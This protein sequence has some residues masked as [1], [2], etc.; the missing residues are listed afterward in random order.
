MKTIKLN[1]NTQAILTNVSRERSEQ[2]INNATDVAN[3]ASQAS[4]ANVNVNA[5][6]SAAGITVTTKPVAPQARLTSLAK[7]TQSLALMAKPS[8]ANNAV[9]SDPHR[10]TRILN[11]LAYT[12]DQRSK[13]ELAE[14]ALAEQSA[15]ANAS[16]NASINANPLCEEPVSSSLEINNGSNGTSENEVS[17]NEVSYAGSASSA[18]SAIRYD[19]SQLAAINTI[20]SSGASSASSFGYVLIGAA[21]SGKTTVINEVVSRLEKAGEIQPLA[22]RRYNGDSISGFNICF[23]S[24]TGKAVEQMRKHIPPRYH[25]CCQ[26]IHSLLEYAPELIESE[27]PDPKSASG[28]KTVTHKVFLPRRTSLNKLP[29]NLFFIDESGMVGVELWNNLYQ[30]IDFTLPNI[31]IVLIG[32]VY[33][34]PAVIGKSVLGYALNSTRWKTNSLTTIHRQALDN[35]IVLNAHRVKQGLAPKVETLPPEL[36]SRFVSPTPFNMLDLRSKGAVSANAEFTRLCRVIQSLFANGHFDPSLDQIITP[37]N[38]GL[39]G[40]ENLNA[41]LAPVFNPASRTAI[42]ISF[43]SKFLAVGDKVMFTSNDYAKGILNGMNGVVTSISLNPKYEYFHEMLRQQEKEANDSESLA[44]NTNEVNS[45][46]DEINKFSLDLSSDRKLAEKELQASHVV[47]VRYTPLGSVVPTEISLSSVGDLRGLLLSYAITCH[48]AQGSEYRRTVVVVHSSQRGLLSREWI[49][50]ALT[51]AKEY[52]LLAY[53]SYGLN[54]ALHTQI[55]KGSSLEEKAAN[56]SLAEAQA[57]AN[58]TK[59]DLATLVPLGF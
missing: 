26:T 27:E 47:T 55:I 59:A 10:G 51:R 8:K 20:C 31:K 28:F 24:F 52:C 9:A 21:G 4:Q 34:L 30:A 35:P 58:K 50:T 15:S 39:F 36:A 23:I 33:Q 38:V 32:D 12:Q 48:K 13:Q 17:E 53:N 1:L 42:R 44:A 54:S 41:T 19:D 14:Q 22:Y 45:V 37:T 7:L 57:R 6:A 25:V 49:Y 40:Q 16:A 29:Q 43:D 11:L 56:F 46:L 2:E 18:S 3:K 5:S